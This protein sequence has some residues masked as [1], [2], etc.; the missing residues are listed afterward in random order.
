M[1]EGRTP[2]TT[3]SFF[4]L[5]PMHVQSVLVSLFHFLSHT[6]PSH[7]ILRPPNPQTALD[8]LFHLYRF[9]RSSLAMFFLY[10]K[11]VRVW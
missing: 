2:Y 7:C 1:V 8:R 5:I 9:V 11:R 3:V 6:Q 4:V 10:A